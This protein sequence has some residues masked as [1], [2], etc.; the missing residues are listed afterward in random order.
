MGAGGGGLPPAATGAGMSRADRDFRRHAIRLLKALGGDGAG[1]VR[2]GSDEALVPVAAGRSIAVPAA[3]LARLESMALVETDGGDRLRISAAGRA[4]LRRAL[5]A[6]PEE[7]FQAQHQERVTR[8]LEDERGR[9]ATV[10]VNLAE[11]PLAWLGRRRDRDGRPL[12]DEVQVKAGERLRADFTRGNLS[13]RVTAN[14]EAPISRG[15]R[16]AGTGLAE[17]AEAA[18][19]ARARVHRALDAVGPELGGVLLDVCC[20]LTGLEET[21]RRHGWPARTGKVVLKLALDRL[22]AHYGYTAAP[23]RRTGTIVHWGAA[24]YRPRAGARSR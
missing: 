14:W 13:A 6:G 1:P 12:I 16:D 2:R 23:N 18:I 24:D 3:V 22:A 4:W 9:R 10:T 11:S 20:F 21:E 7:A 17:L 5:S 15:A 19:D 8:V